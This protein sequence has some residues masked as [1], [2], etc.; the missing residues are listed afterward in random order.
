MRFVLASLVSLL[1]LSAPATA[2]NAEPAEETIVV[3]GQR[4]EQRQSV[5]GRLRDMI[6]EDRASQLSRFEGDICPIVIG[7]PRDL[8]AKLERMIRRNIADAGGTADEPGC[9]PNAAAIFIDQPR[10]FVRALH[11][12]HPGFFYTMNP[13]TFSYFVSRNRSAYSWH[14]VNSYSSDGAII[15]GGSKSTFASRLY[16][17]VRL[18]MESGLVVIDRQAIIGKTLRQL[19]D[20]AT[21]HLMFDIN[22]RS[23]RVDRTSILSLFQHKANA[24]A[25]MSD[26]DRYALRGFYTQRE[27]NRKALMQQTNIAAAIDNQKKREEEALPP[28]NR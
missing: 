6:R 17:P 26:F 3:Q 2:Q 13:R 28:A 1:A 24:P 11:K 16:T 5:I 7:M 15:D 10:D 4:L 27:N 12:A 8:T 20:F 9:K 14:T 21:L 18:E 22:W 25:A 19:A 23:P